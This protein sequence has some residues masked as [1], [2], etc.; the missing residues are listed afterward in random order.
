MNKNAQNI[1]LS[2]AM[3]KRC[4]VSFLVLPVLYSR[5]YL[6]NVVGNYFQ[7]RIEF[8]EFPEIYIC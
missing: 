7:F 8:E 3:I 1:N 2:L 6:L 5:Q 4:W